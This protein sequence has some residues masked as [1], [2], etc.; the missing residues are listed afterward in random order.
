MTSSSMHTYIESI[1][2]GGRCPHDKH[3]I[4]HHHPSKDSTWS[5]CELAQGPHKDDASMCVFVRQDT[6]TQVANRSMRNISYNM[7]C[8][9]WYVSFFD[10]VAQSLV[11]DLCRD[12]I[13]TRT[14]IRHEPNPIQTETEPSESKSSNQESNLAPTRARS[15]NSKRVARRFGWIDA[16]A[17]FRKMHGSCQCCGSVASDFIFN[18]AS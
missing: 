7:S 8:A 1:F 12:R 10:R 6:F 13:W 2:Q 18:F 5:S 15:P 14:K 9:G 11:T 4:H 3:I 17:V 16:S